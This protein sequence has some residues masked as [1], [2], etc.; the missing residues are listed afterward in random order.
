MPHHPHHHH[1]H[2]H[3]PPPPGPILPLPHLTRRSLSSSLLLTD[4]ASLAS[5]LVTNSIGAKSKSVLVKLDLHS[6]SVSCFDDGQG[7]P[8]LALQRHAGE[9]GPSQAPNHPNR[10]HPGTVNLR[11]ETLASAAHLGLLCITTN[12]NP[13][14]ARHPGSP[15]RPSTCVTLLQR[16]D[17]VIY[18]GPPSPHHPQA[19]TS[20]S[21][22]ASPSGTE[23]T[24]RDL[25]HK[26][27]VRRAALGTLAAKRS[28]AEKIKREIGVLSLLHPDISF[29]LIEIVSC[30]DG[31]LST[32]RERCLLKLPK[33]IDS[34]TRFGQVFG[35]GLVPPQWVKP[36]DLSH[37]FVATPPRV[38]GVSGRSLQD[39]YRPLQR[40]TKLSWYTLSVSGFVTPVPSPSRS[41]QRIFLQGVAL[42]RDLRL[43]QACVT[44]NEMVE[45]SSSRS[46]SGESGDCPTSLAG[47]LPDFFSSNRLANAVLEGSE[48]TLH[49]V[50]GRA[51]E[52]VG[53]PLDIRPEDLQASQDQPSTAV[54][55]PPTL[56]RS[57]TR[58]LE[59]CS[60]LV[61]LRVEPGRA[62]ATDGGATLTEKELRC[63]LRDA[64]L[65]ACEIYPG[66]YRVRDA[67]EDER[68]YAEEPIQGRRPRSRDT[69]HDPSDRSDRN[70]KRPKRDSLGRRVEKAVERRLVRSSQ[71]EESGRDRSATRDAEGG[72]DMIVIR[73]TEGM[74]G[75]EEYVEHVDR[76]T[77]KRFLIDTRTGNSYETHH[78]RFRPSDMGPTP[79]VSQRVTDG[80]TTLE[81]EDAD[82]DRFGKGKRRLILGPKGTRWGGEGEKSASPPAWLATALSSW[83]NPTFAP[84]TEEE[85]IPHVDSILTFNNPGIADPP[86]PRRSSESQNSQRDDVAGRLVDVAAPE[87]GGCCVGVGGQDD[88]W[89]RASLSR[90]SRRLALPRVQLSSRFFDEPNTPPPTQGDDR[91]GEEEEQGPAS[92]NLVA[93]TR[94][95]LQGAEMIAQVDLKY[96]VCSVPLVGRG[97]EGRRK[98]SARAIVCI[99]Q[100]AADER[101][102]LER[103]LSDYS[104]SCRSANGSQT[105]E[106]KRP[107]ELSLMTEEAERL[108][109]EEETPSPSAFYQTLT[110]LGFGLSKD[111]RQGAG[112]DDEDEAKDDEPRA[113][114]SI[115]VTHLPSILHDRLVQ[116]RDL[117][118]DVI[119]STLTDDSTPLQTRW[120]AD[121]DRG[122]L[123]WNLPGLL[124]ETIKSKAC[125]GSVMFNQPLERQRCLTM[126]RD[127][128][129]CK[130]PFQC[131]HG[132]CL[133][134]RNGP[135][136][137]W[138]CGRLFPEARKTQDERDSPL[139]KM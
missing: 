56:P 125:R 103:L 30:W 18:F 100:H 110:F 138:R 131:A 47:Q 41:G 58:R 78:P 38:K 114:R 105:V 68:E 23:V 77:R 42:P 72:S 106:L 10:R 116:E 61:D 69:K 14:N 85:E 99:D 16:E 53:Y 55:P 8:E 118:Q 135:P 39:G 67:A 50:L 120:C 12:L 83:K 134:K 24:V 89:A 139:G 94:E 5:K 127:L 133:S 137:D 97:V 40:P 64:I 13:S 81:N 129:R 76:V 49:D 109:G 79:A 122:D 3:E 57:R 73:T 102:R 34:R 98:G 43:G 119:R 36:F 9:S 108:F 65:G 74:E 84:P 21:T 46:K 93:L 28:E 111:G 54:T 104:E 59:N 107:I 20:R 86:I 70:R 124:A 6:W 60:Y 2:H 128:A 48:E 52:Q 7:F 88:R 35:H 62:R 45:M 80:P 91:G 11:G 4:V 121:R 33:V 82:L 101:V 1:H 112:E 123:A 132:S 75:T 32:E 90:R 92:Q 51:L 136:I 25:F 96:L 113:W 44:V 130:F 115:R 71:W 26:L 19:S 63:L 17:K 117:L 29:L 31:D 95:S 22:C 126:I 37:S 87:N 66:P 15:S 27:P